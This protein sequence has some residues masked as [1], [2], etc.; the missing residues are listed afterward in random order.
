MAVV[1]YTKCPEC[2]SHLCLVEDLGVRRGLVTLLRVSCSSCVWSMTV[3]DPRMSKS[4]ALNTRSVL[5]S[6]L[7]GRGRSGIET[8]C[9]I[10]DLPP[11]I[12]GQS[13]ATHAKHIYTR[14]Q[15]GRKT[16]ATSCDESQNPAWG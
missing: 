10:L 14:G 9:A 16:A 7:C 15:I 2:E 3:T 11:P 8:V 6:R 12:T 13:Y 1:Q 4:S 5:G